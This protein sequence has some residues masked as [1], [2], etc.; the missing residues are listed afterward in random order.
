M[1]KPTKWVFAQRR[2]RSAGH[3][4]SL[5][6]VFAVRMKK[7]WVLSYPLSAQRRLW[8]DWVESQAD[9]SLRWAHSHFVVFFM[10]RLIS[11][12]VSFS[13][14]SKLLQETSFYQVLPAL[15]QMLSSIKKTRHALHCKWIRSIGNMDRRGVIFSSPEPKAHWWA[16]GK[17]RHLSSV[18]MY[19]CV[20]V[21]G[22]GCQHNQTSSE[23]SGPIEAKFH[24]E[25]SWDGR[26][27]VCSN[28]PG[29]MTNMAAMPIHC[30]NLKHLLRNQKADDLE[31]WYAASGVRVLPYLFK[32]WPWV[33]RD[34][35]ILRQGQIWSL[36]LF[37]GKKL[38]Q[39]IFQKL[40]QSMISKLVDAVNYTIVRSPGSD[41][42]L[43]LLLRFIAILI[44]FIEL[45]YRFI[46]LL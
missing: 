3:P 39:W 29:H 28:G 33:D 27:K 18:C 42:S 41:I 10:S 24:V 7:P 17:G 14:L 20:C 22:G 35:P 11:V 38:K 25:P 43:F 45:L 19:V 9:L 8:S 12:V 34:W 4:P 31:T 1:T 46:E 15:K 5:I 23:T 44:R 32:W 13:P 6:R 37:H 2:L 30:K 40:L 16:Y 36:M 21:W 26:T